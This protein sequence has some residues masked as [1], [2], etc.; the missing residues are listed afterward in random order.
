MSK[1]LSYLVEARPQAMGHYL[2]FL[3]EAG[4]GLDP[5]TRAL[6]SVITKVHAQTERGF[7]QYVRRALDAGCLPGE[8]LDALLMA[9]PALGLTRI[10]WAVDIILEMDLPGFSPEA[11]RAAQ[12]WQDLCALEDLPEGRPVFVD[13]VKCAAFVRR[14]PDGTVTAF[15]ARCPHQGTALTDDALEDERIVCPR[16]QWAFDAATGECVDH[17]DRPLNRLECRVVDGRVLVRS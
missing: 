3:K 14:E 1:A 5:R 10:V 15:E 16:H 4:S 17:G 12:A 7:R 6:I 2:A 13:N 11:L 9:F 8:I